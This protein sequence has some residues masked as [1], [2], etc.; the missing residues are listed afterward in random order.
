MESWL[1][2]FWSHLHTAEGLR[3]L[4]IAGGLGI[5]CLIIFAETGLLAGFFLPGDSLLVTA[6]VLSATSG[7][8]T[9][10]FSPWA[11]TFALSFSAIIGNQTGYWLGRKFGQ[12]AETRSDSWFFK[13][14]HLNAAREYFATKGPISLLLARFVPIFRTFVPFAAG[15][16]LMQ[17]RTFLR[18]NIIGGLIWVGSLTWLGH[19]IGGTPLADELHKVILILVAAS[20]LPVAWGVMSRSLTSARGSRSEK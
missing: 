3:Q 17:A 2:D 20:F 1:V 12:R 4:I 10:L 18:W 11:V 16:G 5:M 7:D 6:G 15:M 9:A 13:R 19:L 8:R 14:R